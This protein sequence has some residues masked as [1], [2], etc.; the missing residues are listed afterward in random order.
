MYIIDTNVISE[1]R[2]RPH[3]R[4]ENVSQW[5]RSVPI[6]QL[7][8]SAITIYELDVG[9]RRLERRDDTQGQKLRQWFLRSVLV[10]FRDKIL[11]FDTAV[12]MRAAAL[13]VPDQRPLADSFIAATAAEHDMQVVTRNTQDFENMNI[14]VINPFEYAG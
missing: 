12:A 5:I 13:H 7:Y 6:T 11:P 3:R 2:R 9:I 10:Q 14:D 1:L 8:L 4:N